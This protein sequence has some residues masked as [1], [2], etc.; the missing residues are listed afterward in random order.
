MLNFNKRLY[1]RLREKLKEIQVFCLEPS[2]I[3]QWKIEV[4]KIYN[5]YKNSVLVETFD[6]R[7]KEI[8]ELRRRAEAHAEK[9][10]KNVCVKGVHWRYPIKITSRITDENKIR[11]RQ[12]IVMEGI[13]ELKYTKDPLIAYYCPSCSQQITEEI[14]REERRR[15]ALI[16]SLERTMLLAFS[17]PP[18]YS[19]T[20]AIFTTEEDI[21]MFCDILRHHA[22]NEEVKDYVIPIIEE[23][24]RSIIRDPYHSL[25]PVILNPHCKLTRQQI[26]LYDQPIS[27]LTKEE[28]ERVIKIKRDV[29]SELLSKFMYL[30]GI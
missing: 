9:H 6:Q 19:P 8:E 20:P 10:R 29:G 12:R 15:I 26:L 7:L 4:S 2:L 30:K 28:I 11:W 21:K 22:T 18:G 16:N 27:F 3:H 14:C 23:G 25:K 1:R 24:V 5:D 17:P 13:D